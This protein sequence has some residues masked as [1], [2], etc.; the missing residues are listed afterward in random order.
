M[1]YVI[2][3]FLTD[4]ECDKYITE[5]DNKTKKY[6]FSNSALSENDKYVDTG[7]ARSFYDKFISRIDLTDSKIIGPNKW[8]MTS[9]Y[10]NGDEFGIHT[11]TGL[12]FDLVNNVYST[13]TVLIYLNDN[14]EG[15]ETIFYDNYFKETTRIK[16][17]K[18]SLLIFSMDL[19][20][21]GSKV[22]GT[23][24]WI[25]CEFVSSECLC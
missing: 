7:L 9:K 25:G 19:F 11:D 15:G 16:P 6:P 1:I 14:F 23:K 12:C 13:H 10:N 21:K 5:I 3:S 4:E 17:K 8:I 20:H 24:Y 18:G 2:D 22:S